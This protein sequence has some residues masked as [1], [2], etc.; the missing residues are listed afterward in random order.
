MRLMQL[1]MISLP[2][3]LRRYGAALGLALS[4]T[5][6]A[7]LMSQPQQEAGP[8]VARHYQE[9]I[10]LGG[11]MS[12]RYTQNNQEQAV[13]GSFTWDQQSRHIVLSLLSPLGQTLATIDIRPGMAVLKQSDKV[14]L[15]AADVDILTEQALGWPL[16]VAGLRDWLQGFGRNR[17]GQ[18]FV[19]QPA[20]APQRLQT[21]DGWTL[22]YGEWQDDAANTVQ[23][24]PKRI[25]L[26]RDTK[27]AGPVSIR[28]VIDK[29]QP[30]DNTA[31]KS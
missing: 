5:G 12:I 10:A 23:N 26:S 21:P 16:P 24:H 13:H 6:C 28:I 1:Q 27:Q 8:P 18:P 22:T 2:A 25:D 19:A 31:G 9:N 29:W 20:Q 3:T 17:D 11:R 14:P 15:S 7:G 4:L 30:S